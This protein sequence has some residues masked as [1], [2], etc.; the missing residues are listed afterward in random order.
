MSTENH[1]DAKQSE[2]ERQHKGLPSRVRFAAILDRLRESE[3]LTRQIN[4]LIRTYRDRVECDA[5]NAA[6]VQISHEGLV[7][8]LLMQAMQDT[9]REIEHFIY[10]T[11]YGRRPE[12]DDASGG[13]RPARF[14]TAEA[15]Y[16]YLR[17]K[18][19]G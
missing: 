14:Q 1:S 4:A 7:V 2:K 17:G 15:L 10:E 9:E 11:D 6:A 3:D 5:C 13:E 16:D 18:M 8:E 19:E 12:L